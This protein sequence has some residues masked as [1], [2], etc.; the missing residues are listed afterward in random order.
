MPHYKDG[1]PAKHGDLIIHREPHD[2]G[3][4]KVMI[5]QSI[6]PSSDAC[7]AAAIPIAIRQ[8]GSGVWL[9]LAHQLG[10]CITLKECEK[11]GDPVRATLPQELTEAQ[12]A[13]VGSGG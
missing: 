10:W 13:A 5:V 6:T 11:V 2:G 12:P 9:P 7:N 3:N 4:E 8:K 1:T